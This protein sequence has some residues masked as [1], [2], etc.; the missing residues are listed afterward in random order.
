MSR[1]TD[2]ALSSPET[3]EKAIVLAREEHFWVLCWLRLEKREGGKKDDSL[4]ELMPNVF[5]EIIQGN[6]NRRELKQCI[7]E[8]E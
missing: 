2:E 3:M 7:L 6:W 4:A 1:A 8:A 5:I